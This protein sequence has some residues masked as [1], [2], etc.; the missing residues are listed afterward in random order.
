MASA[1]LSPDS[2]GL[3]PT[4]LARLD[5]HIRAAV[6]GGRIPGAVLGLARHGRFLAPRCYGR[7][8]LASD[9][10][11][12]APDTIFLVASVTKPVTVLAA[13]LLVERGQLS[14][15]DPVCDHIPAFGV[16]GKETVRIRHLMTHT[17][18]LPDMLPENYALRQ[19]HAPL[20]EF[21]RRVC[22]LPLDF[23]P[24]THIQYQSM[25]LLML[26]QVVERITGTALP[27]LM[28]GEVFAPLGMADT[29]LGIG[30]LPVARV[31]EVNI[32]P[33][34]VGVDWGWNMPYWR[35][36]GAPWGGMF[37]TVS[38]TARLM[39]LFLNGGELDGVRILS[40]AT[41]RAMTRDQSSHLP[42]MPREVRKGQSWGLGWRR[43][44]ALGWSYFG[45]LLSPCAY[46]HGGAT[47]TTVWADPV[48]EMVCVLYTTEPSVNSG[49]FLGRCSSMVAGLAE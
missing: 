30:S 7:R 18:G 45:D 43:N 3:S 5:D 29:S 21:A 12:M 22:A 26:A 47:G 14:L 4:G 1:D 11:P 25:G 15:D 49:R 6:E 38:D 44:G 42:A 34:M 10:P 36:L 35:E 33:E 13:M 28:R 16:N 19:E 31:A 48:S 2:I 20:D 24:G 40:P 39:Q 23:A 46:G 37:S 9:G 32:G 41:V 17:S 8:T 27:D